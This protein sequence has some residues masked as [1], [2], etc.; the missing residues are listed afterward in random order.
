[1]KTTVDLLKDHLTELRISHD[2]FEK[3]M[4]M[5]ISTIATAIEY[6]LNKPER[7]DWELMSRLKTQYPK[8]KL[9]KLRTAK[10]AKSGEI[11]R[12]E[13]S[14]K[15]EQLFREEVGARLKKLRKSRNIS[16]ERMA[17][18]TGDQ[19][20]TYSAIENARTH[21]SCYRLF[22]YSKELNTSFETIITGNSTN[23]HIGLQEQ[24]KQKDAKIAELNAQIDLLKKNET[25]Y[26][27]LLKN[28]GLK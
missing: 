20:S 14:E 21:L 12:D 19:A 16:A 7:A 5:K 1:M 13:H 11:N 15:F 17:S 26:N 8:I 6:S 22:F 18:L 27:E 2:A 23:D 24:I 9:E 3:K 25:L 4:G 28:K 10:K